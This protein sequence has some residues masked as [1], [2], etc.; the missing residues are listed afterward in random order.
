MAGETTDNEFADVVVAAQIQDRPMVPW[1]VTLRPWLFCLMFLLCAELGTRLYYDTGY[2][3]QTE[4]FDNFPTPALENAYVAQMRRDPAYKIAVIGDSTVVGAALLDQKDYVPNQLQAALRGTLPN[5][6]IHVWNFGVAGAR[7]A[8]MLCIFKKVQEG[9]PDFVIIGGSYYITAIGV[10]RQPL[11]EP[12][13]AYN[14]SQIPAPIR[15]IL[16][17]RDPKKQWEEELVKHVEENFRLLGMRQALNAHLFGVQP[18]FPYDIAN[19]GVMIG[20]NIAKKMHKLYPTPYYERGPGYAPEH[21]IGFYAKDITE[22]DLN[23]SFYRYLMQEVQNSGIPGLTYLTPQNPAMTGFALTRDNYLKRR[24]ILSSFFTT[25]G[26]IHRDYC[27]LI[28]SELFTD[29]DHLLP[30]GN[31][32]LAVALAN[33][34]R[35]T[36]QHTMSLRASN[37]T[38]HGASNVT[39]IH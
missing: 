22:D 15:Q 21:Y 17:D 4:R 32:R 26:I 33:E 2:S 3:L 38:S 8:D 25:P 9:R 1:Y 10:A 23:G 28:P 11:A 6:E 36:I 34:I 31:Q 14:L 13:L 39:S 16:P 37:A 18:R 20:T 12:W 24:K 27:D 29:N 30:A 19:P 5:R 35:P 7:A